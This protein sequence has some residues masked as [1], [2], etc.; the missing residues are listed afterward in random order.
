MKE[1]KINVPTWI[2]V[3]SALFGLMEL[4]VSLLLVFSPAS[5]V[6]TVDVHARGVEYLI[7]MWAARQF[8][9]GVI[10][11]YATLKRSAP[12]LILAYLFFLVM[13]AGD[14]LIGIAQKENSL[15][16]SAIVMCIVSAVMIYLISKRARNFTQRAQREATDA[17]PIS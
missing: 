7:D 6:Q 17:K 2:L 5:V 13:F 15:V 16:I 10:F 11:G 4:M 8:A 14:L 1:V 9:L 12:M 3:V